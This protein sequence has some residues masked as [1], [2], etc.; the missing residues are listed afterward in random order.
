M[1]NLRNSPFLWFAL[2]LLVAFGL[3]QV[4][5]LKMNQVNGIFLATICLTSGIVCIRKYNPGFQYIS[6]IAIT[7]LI[8]AAGMLGLYSSNQLS[9]LLNHLR[10][11]SG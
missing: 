8:I 11:P 10:L 4:L 6:T 5:G 9:A 7:A 3:A 2:L 1:I